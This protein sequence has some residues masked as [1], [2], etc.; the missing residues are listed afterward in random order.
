MSIGGGLVRWADAHMIGGV[1]WRLENL[2]VLRPGC[3][4]GSCNGALRKVRP[5]RPLGLTEA[6]HR[7]SGY[8]YRCVRC[9]CEFDRSEIESD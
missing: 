1:G 9:G 6:E 7:E 5:D 3:P 2:M 8:H 4:A